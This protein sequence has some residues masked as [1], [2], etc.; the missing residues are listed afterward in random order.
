MRNPLL[1]ARQVAGLLNIRPTTV[2]ALCRRGELPHVRVTQGTR[3][4][5]IRFRGED[6]ERLIKERT[7]ER[8]RG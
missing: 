5:L 2:Y 7:V 1:T 3:R 8:P 6:I 4:A